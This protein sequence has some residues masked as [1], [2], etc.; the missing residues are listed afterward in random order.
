MIRVPLIRILVSYVTAGAGHRRAAE[1]LAQALGER[2]PH[3]EIRCVDVLTYASGRFRAFYAWTYLFLVRHA[4]WVW[5]IGYGLLDRGPIYRCVQ[6]LRRR[7]NL[8]I[9]RRFVAWLKEQPPDLVVVTHFLAADVCSAGRE[10]GWLAAPLVVVVTD[11]HPHRFWVSLS[12]DAMV[13]STTEGADVLMRCG[14]AQER[15]RILGIPIANAFSAPVDRAALRE[16]FHLHPDRLTVLVTSGGTTVGRFESVVESLCSLEEIAPG[17]VQLLVVCGE[18]AA[19]QA[20]LT[21]RAK[22]RPMPMQVFGF[23]DYMPDLMAVSSL[24]VA[25]AGGL[26]VSEALGRGVPLVLYHVIPGQEQLNAAYVVRRG[27]AVLAPHPPDVAQAVLRLVQQPEALALMREAVR[28]ISHPES[29][30][31]IVS[32]VIGPFLR[33]SGG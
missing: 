1:A 17:R 16:R 13:I 28:T 20:R 14:I 10:Q 19:S 21:Q 5:R 23:V 29:A 33:S 12:A 32:E 6:P 31:A 27:A 22:R 11:M 26:T 15:V 18:D 8:H 2:Y 3:A 9:A 25:K 4:Q 7:W 30:G 24:I